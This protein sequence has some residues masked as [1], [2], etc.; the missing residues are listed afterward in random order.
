MPPAIW[1]QYSALVLRLVGRCATRPA[2]A[3]LGASTWA[4]TGIEM[5]SLE[6]QGPFYVVKRA[7]VGCWGAGSLAWLTWSYIPYARG[8]PKS[9]RLGWSGR[10]SRLVDALVTGPSTWRKTNDVN[11]PTGRGAASGVCDGP[12]HPLHSRPSSI[13]AHACRAW[14]QPL[15]VGPSR[16]RGPVQR[17]PAPPSPSL[18]AAL[19]AGIPVSWLH[20]A[21][22]FPAAVAPI[23][24]NN[25]HG[26]PTSVRPDR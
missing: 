24:W 6:S 1:I 5:H 19:G 12:V 7:F 21:S 13:H 14:Y 9:D 22:F 15:A 8:R 10:G 16:G 3:V 20:S 18:A 11:N 4:W 17:G 25:G 26:N 2:R 23:V